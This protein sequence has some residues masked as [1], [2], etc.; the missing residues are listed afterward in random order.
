[1]VNLINFSSVFEIT[2]A[3]NSLLFFFEIKPG[4]LASYYK[5][6]WG[7]IEETV[8]TINKLEGQDQLNAWIETVNGF[9]DIKKFKNFEY[10][11]SK[12]T[13][14][15]SAIS[16]LVLIVSGFFPDLKLSCFFTAL[17]L[18]WLIISPISLF[19]MASVEGKESK[20]IGNL[21][22]APSHKNREG[23]K[24]GN[25]FFRI[26]PT[27]CFLFSIIIGILDI[28]DKKYN[29]VAIYI[30]TH[31]FPNFFSATAF[32]FLILAIILHILL[33]HIKNE[34]N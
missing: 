19:N 1:M 11:I 25:S 13:I 21:T 22:H 31:D 17:L 33:L 9:E 12:I 2:F 10:F 28:I 20:G 7:S 15:N 16:L 3:L 24:T 4:A 6:K 27:C 32:F 23:S 34:P 14:I 26:I 5:K 30:G 29:F 18:I 8:Q